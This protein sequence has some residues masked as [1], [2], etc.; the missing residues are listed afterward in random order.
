MKKFDTITKPAQLFFLSIF[1]LLFFNSYAHENYVP[2]Q[3]V[4]GVVTDSATSAPLASVSVRVKGKSVA[5]TTNQQG[6]YTI[7]ADNNSTLI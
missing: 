6:A 2:P 3:T 5:T 1:L 4:S 7:I